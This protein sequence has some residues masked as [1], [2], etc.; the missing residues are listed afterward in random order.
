MQRLKVKDNPKLIR[1]ANS[2]GI[3]NTDTLAYKD[4]L[5]KKKLLEQNELEKQDT[6][7]RINKL[8]T[9]VEFLKTG[10]T[11]ILELLKK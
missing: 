6:K 8:E 4:Y 1:D 2:N 10:I 5:R 3:I 11:Q 7:N 9:D